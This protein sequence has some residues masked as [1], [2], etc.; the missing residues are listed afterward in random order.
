MKCE[1]YGC[2]KCECCGKLPFMASNIANIVN[3]QF[4]FVRFLDHY[5]SCYKYLILDLLRGLNF[6][7][8]NHSFILI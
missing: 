7:K 4:V 1:V 6:I 8:L 3:R 2:L 5:W